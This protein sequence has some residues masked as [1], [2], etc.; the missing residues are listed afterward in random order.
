[1]YTLGYN[2]NDILSQFQSLIKRLPALLYVD[3]KKET[4]YTDKIGTY[5]D[6]AAFVN[7][8]YKKV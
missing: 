4:V 5:E 3:V 8:N 7:A 6:V 1:M 2:N